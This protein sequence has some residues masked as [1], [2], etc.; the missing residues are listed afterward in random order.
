MKSILIILFLSSFIIVAQDKGVLIGL[1]Y[2]EIDSTKVYANLSDFQK[3]KTLWIV[4]ENN[5][6]IL[7][8]EFPELIVPKDTSFLRI[9]LKRSTY[10]EW[11]QDF[12]WVCS[13]KDSPKILGIDKQHGENHSGYDELNIFFVNSN[14]LSINETGE[15]YAKLSGIPA[16]WSDSYL[17]NLGSFLIKKWDDLIDLGYHIPDD[18]SSLFGEKFYNDFLNEAKEYRDS[19]ER[20]EEVEELPSG[21]SLYRRNGRLILD[22]E[23]GPSAMIF[24]ERH[25]EFEVKSQL[26]NEFL[27]GDNNNIN[28]Q[29]IQNKFPDAKDAL[30]SPDK[31]ILLILN[32]NKI[33]LFNISNN[34]IS[35]KPN[36]EYRLDG[37]NHSILMYKWAREGK[38]FEWTKIFSEVEDNIR[39]YDIE[40]EFDDAL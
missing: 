21:I 8:N 12:V 20:K 7:K 22:A 36:F 10:N 27:D 2:E 34:I 4:K 39:M 37:N 5:N 9:G 40:F 17:I 28:W 30:V 18:L 1:G 23:F 31:N 19:L 14:Y 6:F 16:Y 3:L 11:S 33:Q 15:D 35:E 13:I 29:D 26:P 24:R 38:V 25:E 32:E